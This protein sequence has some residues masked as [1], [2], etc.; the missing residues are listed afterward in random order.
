MTLIVGEYT[1]S[2][3]GKATSL[4]E[5]KLLIQTSFIPLEKLALC[6]IWS[7]RTSLNTITQKGIL[8][9]NRKILI[10]LTSKYGFKISEARMY[11][12]GGGWNHLTVCQQLLYL[13]ANKWALAHL[14]ILSTNYAFTNHIY[15]EREREGERI[16]HE[17]TY[18]GWY[19]IKHNQIIYI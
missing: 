13:C 1:F 7:S 5:G 17:I 2:S 16:W 3:F 15:I 6:H 18:K 9:V 14:K 19:A 8:L 12:T 10:S 4:E 11:A